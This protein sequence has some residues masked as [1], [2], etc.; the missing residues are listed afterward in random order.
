MSNLINN[1]FEIKK[2]FID[3]N[4]IIKLRSEIK[5]ILKQ[6]VSIKQRNKSID[7]MYKLISKKSE[8][9]KGNIYD[10][11]SKLTTCLSI[12][13][14]KE[15]QGYLKKNKFKNL[16]HHGSSV[17][18]MEANK[19]KF[20]FDIHQDLR[21]RLSKS[22]ILIWIP[23]SNYSKDLGGIKVWKNSNKLGI[24]KHDIVENGTPK[25]KKNILSK[26]LKLNSYEFTNF[27]I[28]DVLFMSPYCVHSSIPNNSKLN[29]I[30][31]TLVVQV[32]DNTNCKHLKKSIHP[33]KIKKFMNIK[34]MYFKK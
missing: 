17:L 21:N 33:F 4:Y 18:I 11:I 12:L 6:H 2:N 22:A 32:D 7:E 30:R 24:L 9:L 25:L 28:G 34:N 20:L 29:K 5:N 10:V 3:K 26:I 8:K 14:S 27:K 16:V 15:I 31:W 19:K 13:Y 23:I 1:G